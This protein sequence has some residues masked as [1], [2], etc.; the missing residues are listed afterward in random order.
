MMDTA[1][2][3]LPQA[4]TTPAGTAV[5]DTATIPAAVDTEITTA[6]GAVT[7]PPGIAIVTV[8]VTMMITTIM[9]TT[10]TGSTVPRLLLQI[11]NP[12]RRR[13]L[14]KSAMGTTITPAPRKR[15]NMKPCPAA[16]RQVLPTRAAARRNR[17][18]PRVGPTSPPR[19]MM[20]KKVV[21]TRAKDAR[22]PPLQA[23]EALANCRFYI[24]GKT[25]S[26]RFSQERWIQQIVSSTDK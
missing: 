23:D 2:R 19:M 12:R 14:P 25:C 26:V 24:I 17:R 11:G 10:G 4:D 18:P 1:T 20:T 8:T 21:P 5:P 22:H 6:V 7:V 9:I 3:I 16:S 15:G 13:P